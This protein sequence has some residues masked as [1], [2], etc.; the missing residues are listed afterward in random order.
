MTNYIIA[1]PS[2]QAIQVSK[3]LTVESYAIIVDSYWYLIFVL[4]CNFG[5][6]LMKGYCKVAERLFEIDY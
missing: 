4:F 6:T 2:P 3:P 1:F 5:I